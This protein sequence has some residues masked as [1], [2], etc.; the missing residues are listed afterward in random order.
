MTVNNGCDPKMHTYTHQWV[1]A[2][3]ICHIHIRSGL[4]TH[5]FI[6]YKDSSRGGSKLELEWSSSKN[7]ALGDQ[8]LHARYDHGLDP[9]SLDQFWL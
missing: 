6:I 4:E 8:P 3:H 7:L 1:S 5:T 2:S 9:E